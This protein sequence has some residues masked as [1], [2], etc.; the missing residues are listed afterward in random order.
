MTAGAVWL[1]I[2]GTLLGAFGGTALGFYLTELVSRRAQQAA[3]AR[4]LHELVQY[5]HPPK[6]LLD[7]EVALERLIVGLRVLGVTEVAIG[8][9]R[10]TARSCHESA[11]SF[12][13]AMP[14]HPSGIERRAKEEYEAVIAALS[15]FL[16]RRAIRTH[17]SKRLRTLIDAIPPASTNASDAHPVEPDP[18]R[19]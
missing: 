9:L 12:A 17:R 13:A 10:Q 19:P 11:R 6:D 14:G 18:L 16:Q 3:T 2:G 8:R 7:L 15:A 5:L 1:G 4:E